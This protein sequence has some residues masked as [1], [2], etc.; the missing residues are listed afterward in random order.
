MSLKVPS[1]ASL[2]TAKI[3]DDDCMK[4]PGWLDYTTQERNEEFVNELRKAKE[5]GPDVLIECIKYKMPNWILDMC[6]EYDKDLSQLSK[7]WS[8]LCN[9]FHVPSQKILLV[10]LIAFN[11]E[12]D[13]SK[14]KNLMLVADLLTVSGFVVKD[15]THFMMCKGCHKLMISEHAQKTLWATNNIWKVCRECTQTQ[16]K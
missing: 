7:N 14:H 11:E 9:R 10:D 4:S 6:T 8:S 15:K 5:M 1:K 2:I 3:S 13:K 12:I 16:N